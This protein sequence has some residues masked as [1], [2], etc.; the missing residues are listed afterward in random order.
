MLAGR[1]PHLLPFPFSATNPANLS[2]AAKSLQVTQPLSGAGLSFARRRI[3]Q[4]A[5][6]AEPIPGAE[7]Y[8]K[9]EVVYAVT[10]EG[11]L[12]LEDVLTRRT[13]ISIRR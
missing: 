11:A 9:A 10:H 4:D 12:H 1:D 6:L 7:P 5:S 8:L 3:E 13:R 2:L